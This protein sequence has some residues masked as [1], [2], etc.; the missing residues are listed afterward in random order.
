MS[1]TFTINTAVT[2]GPNTRFWEAAGSDDLYWLTLEDAGQTMLNRMQRTGT[3]RYL[4]N[5]YTLSSRTVDGRQLGCE[6][7]S[8]DEKGNVRYDFTKINAVYQEF[9]RRGIKPIVEYDYLPDVLARQLDRDAPEREEGLS[10][11]D[12][13]PKDWGKWADLL[14]A[15]TRN[16]IDT[17]GQEEVRTW[18]FEVWNEPDGWAVEDLPTFFKMYDV[19]VDAVTSVDDKL[20]VGGPATFSMYFLRDFLHHVTRGTNHVTGK[21][22]TRID[23]VS[24]HIYG[25]SGGWV[26]EHPLVRP[27]VQRFVQEVLWIQR[28]LKKYPGLEH[29]EFHM[30]EWGVCSNYQRT[31]A[32]HPALEYRNSEFSALF[33]TK[34][35]HLLYAVE[36]AFDFP[37]SVLLYWGFAFETSTGEFFRGN[38][39]LLTAGGVP[40][41]IQTAHE[42]LAHLGEERLLVEGPKP[43]S[44]LG[45]L[46]TRTG[47]GRLELFVYHFNELDDEPEGE[48][49][50]ELTLTGLGLE[51]GTMHVS[52]YILDD[53]RHN[54]YRAWQRLGSPSTAECADLP[55]L[56]RVG[57]LSVD[58]TVDIPV[59]A[60]EASLRFSMPRHSMR[61]YVIKK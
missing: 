38:R 19:F 23:F 55:A 26:H 33:L 45:V 15:F 14:K 7:Y 54:T 17:F 36:D 37:T 47:T 52:A 32:Q 50:V 6:V 57:E 20:R 48:E 61:L 49:N 4:R 25:L 9:V 2:V 5:H 42:L 8:E 60:G 30:N 46:A 35:V 21:T 53:E 16:L 56:L 51:S 3:C 43:G 18:Y 1:K 27:T 10:A 59:Q 29:V 12:K 24:H 40:K 13:G 22:G 34:L 11:S 31:V 41:P 39:D 58:E 44:S 28:L